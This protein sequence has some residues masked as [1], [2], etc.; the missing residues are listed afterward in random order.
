MAVEMGGEK[1]LTEG[2]GVFLAGVLQ[3]RGAP[4]LF[5]ALDDPGRQPVFEWIGVYLKQAVFGLLKD[6]GK[7]LE[8]LVGAE[9]GELAAPPVET[10]LEV[11]GKRRSH[12]RVHPVGGHDEIGVGKLVERLHLALELELDPE[13]AAAAVEDHQQPFA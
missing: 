3:P 9:P 12:P 7:G 5:A 6:E 4:Y 1:V 8:R 13:L 10:R 11:L 2:D